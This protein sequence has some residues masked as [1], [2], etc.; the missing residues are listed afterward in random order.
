VRRV[1]SASSGSSRGDLRPQGRPP[2]LHPASSSGGN[3]RV[4]LP[5]PS[6][7]TADFPPSLAAPERSPSRWPGSA[8]VAAGGV[9]VDDR[10]LPLPRAWTWLRRQQLSPSI[11]LRGCGHGGRR[12]TGRACCRGAPRLL[13]P[14][15]GAN[16]RRRMRKRCAQRCNAYDRFLLN[17]CRKGNHN[18]VISF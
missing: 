4:Q 10:D 3:E 12:G 5:P 15:A 18:R 14:A 13:R 1:T 7:T 16:D 8:G 9:L 2:H 17:S 6:P 11:W